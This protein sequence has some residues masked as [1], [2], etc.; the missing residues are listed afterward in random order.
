MNQRVVLVLFFMLFTGGFS[1]AAAG[2]PFQRPAV[3]AAS[4][5]EPTTITGRVFTW[6]QST[7]RELRGVIAELIRDFKQ[8]QGGLPFLLIV[9]CSFLYGVIHAVGPGHGKGIIM[10]FLLSER[11]PKLTRGLLAGITVA[12]GEALSAVIIVYAI[13]YLALG[14]ITSSFQTT[15]K[16]IRLGAYGLILLLG[17]ALFVYRLCRQLPVFRKSRHDSVLHHDRR[18]GLAAAVL[19]GLIPCPG[20]MLLLIF[21]LT[22]R[23]PLWG[24][25]FAFSMACGMAVTIS[26][27]AVATVVAKTHLVPALFSNLKG[28]GFIEAAIEL[29][30]AALIVVLSLFMLA[31]G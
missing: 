24:L 17:I 15:E 26:L 12:F 10:S 2:S 23:L 28:V 16:Q 6:I 19:L 18:P 22:A 5:Q 1:P 13:Y 20:V 7:Q 11:N 8:Q 4:P 29:S 14:R 27:F 30:G 21:M 9:G 25:A 31:G 3:P